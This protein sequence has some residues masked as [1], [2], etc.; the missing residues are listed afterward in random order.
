MLQLALD[1]IYEDTWHKYDKQGVSEMPYTYVLSY[2]T[3]MT[4][5]FL[6]SC[7]LSNAPLSP[8]PFMNY[9]LGKTIKKKIKIKNGKLTWNSNEAIIESFLFF[10]R[11]KY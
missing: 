4:N 5:F 8:I 7:A 11:P 10:L 9:V 1:D 6:E 3:H 2:A